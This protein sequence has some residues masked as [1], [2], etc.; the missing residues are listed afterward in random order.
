M[1]KRYLLLVLA[2]FFG[3][4][5]LA[6]ERYTNELVTEDVHQSVDEPDYYG[7]N[8]RH[9]RFNEAGELE[10]SLRA[11][12]SRHFDQSGESILDQ[13]VVETTDAN[14]QRWQASAD[15]GLIADSDAEIRLQGNV[16]LESRDQS[17]PMTI[18]TESLI[19]NPDQS[20]AS[21][22]DWVIITDGT[23]ETRSQG[24]SVDTNRQRIELKQHVSTR[25]V[26][27]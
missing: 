23:S 8:L 17:K 3:M 12:A 5:L 18:T 2:V 16:L 15:R 22:D 14:Q 20:R 9:R 19:Y 11:E 13:P 27:E 6:V 21:T 24:L 4:S 7:E 26:Q 25:Y 10:Q 1:R